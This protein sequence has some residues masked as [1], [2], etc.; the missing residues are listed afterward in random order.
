MQTVYLGKVIM[1]E[2][3]VYLYSIFHFGV[4]DRRFTAAYIGIGKRACMLKGRCDRLG[5]MPFM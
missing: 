2:K 3:T 4:F 5:V 1:Q